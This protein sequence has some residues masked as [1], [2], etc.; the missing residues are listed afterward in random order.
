MKCQAL[1]SLKNTNKNQTVVCASVLISFFFFFF[2]ECPKVDFFPFFTDDFIS[3]LVHI[4]LL[5]KMLNFYKR[6]AFFIAKNAEFLLKVRIY[7]KG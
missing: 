6:K 7:S 1:F 2:L 5:L 3:A 4:K